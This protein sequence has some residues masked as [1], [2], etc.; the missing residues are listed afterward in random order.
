MVSCTMFYMVYKYYLYKTKRPVQP[1][2][3]VFAFLCGFPFG[4]GVTL[5][6]VNREIEKV[7]VYEII[8]INYL[9]FL[10]R[11]LDLQIESL[12]EKIPVKEI[13]VEETEEIKVE[14]EKSN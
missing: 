3:G 7:K 1:I 12:D 8:N 4:L 9:K 6:Y 10:N 5:P 14:Q 2:I 13:P 11:R